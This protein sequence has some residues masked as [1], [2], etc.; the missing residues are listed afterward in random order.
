MKQPSDPETSYNDFYNE[1]H[2][3]ANNIVNT[4]NYV[5]R[6]GGLQMH[7]ELDEC[8]NKLSSL[9]DTENK[10]AEEYTSVA[11][12][13]KKIFD[14][15]EKIFAATDKKI[16]DATAQQA[17]ADKDRSAESVVNPFRKRVGLDEVRKGSSF[18]GFIAALEAGKMKRNL[19]R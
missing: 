14:A 7:R 17:F 3:D 13:I 2:K 18:K 19:E 4:L 10:D 9:L 6:I 15:T 12:S 8:I 16:F 11:D 1:L 5:R